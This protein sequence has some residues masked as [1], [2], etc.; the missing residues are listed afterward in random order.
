MTGRAALL[1]RT[2]GRRRQL[3]GP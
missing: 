3:V 1:L 2:A